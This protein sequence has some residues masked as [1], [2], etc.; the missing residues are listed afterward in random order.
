MTLTDNRTL[1]TTV[2]IKPTDNGLYS[3]YN[4]YT[5]D[6]YKKSVV[7]TLVHRALK[8]TSTWDGFNTEINRIKQ[9]LSNNNFPQAIIER[10]IARTLDKHHDAHNIGPTDPANTIPIFVRLFSPVTFTRDKNQLNSILKE[11]LATINNEKTI[12]LQPYYKPTKLGSKFSTR[13]KQEDPLKSSHVVYQY[14][15]PKDGCNA[16]YIG[17]TTCELRRRVQQHQYKSS[18]I[19]KHHNVDHPEDPNI[20]QDFKKQFAIVH[21]CSNVTNLRT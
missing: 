1:A 20:P 6:A 17:Y 8:Y 16:S 13:P 10:I 11:H 12:K 21:R 5:P 9:T 7:K 2:Y 3:D 18:S 19:Y 14:S 4:S 15:C